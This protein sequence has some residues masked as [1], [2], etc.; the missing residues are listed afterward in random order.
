MCRLAFARPRAGLWLV[1][2]AGLALIPPFVFDEGLLN[3]GWHLVL[4]RHGIGATEGTLGLSLLFGVI[5]SRGFIRRPDRGPKV[6]NAGDIDRA[7][8]IPPASAGSSSGPGSIGRQAGIGFRLREAFLM[9]ARQGRSLIALFDPVGPKQLWAHLSPASSLR[10]G[11]AVA[12]RSFTM[13]SA[14]F[15]PIAVEMHLQALKLGEQ[16]W[17]ISSRFCLPAVH[18]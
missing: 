18:G 4:A 16:R 17:W 10:R 15:L 5:A 3:F 13:V 1:A 8:A 6:G 11:V 7:I 2:G 9:Y 12:V 14:D